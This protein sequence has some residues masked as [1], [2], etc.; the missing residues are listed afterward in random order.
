M[1]EQETRQATVTT[2][3]EREIRVEREFDAPRERVFAVYTDPEL[4]PEWWGPRQYTT[5]VDYMEPRTGGRWRFVHKD[6]EG[7]AIG[8]QGAYREVTAPERIVQTF[9]WEGMAG[10]VSVETA[11]FEDLGD[12]R[13]KVTTVSVFHTTEERDGMLGSGMEWGMNETFQRLDELLAKQG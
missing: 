12:G 10:H 7:N 9:E 13:T 11:T 1:V 4:I 5:E 3:S 2:P 8:F 6:D